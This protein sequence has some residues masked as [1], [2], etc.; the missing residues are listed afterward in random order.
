MVYTGKLPP[1]KHN[2]NQIIAAATSLQMTDVALD[3]KNILTSLMKQPSTA[4]TT[5]LIITQLPTQKPQGQE[6]DL[7]SSPKNVAANLGK[8][9]VETGVDMKREM[10]EMDEGGVLEKEEDKDPQDEKMEKEDDSSL[11]FN[12]DWLHLPKCT[13]QFQSCDQ[14]HLS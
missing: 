9:D 11:P 14:I 8:D 2:L 5:A 7:T 3:C 4:S 1:G 13:G 10:E 12:R 6:A